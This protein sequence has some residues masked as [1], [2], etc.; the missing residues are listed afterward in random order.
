MFSRL[1][2]RVNGVGAQLSY[3]VHIGM[4]TRSRVAL[5]VRSTQ[6]RTSAEWEAGER[7]RNFLAHLGS[8]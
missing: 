7:D 1:T 2:L 6:A 3:L 5:G 4:D 8:W